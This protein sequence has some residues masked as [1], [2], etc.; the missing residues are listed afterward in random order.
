[1]FDLITGKVQHAPRHQTLPVFISVAAHVTIV[2]AMVT[3]TAVAVSDD[4]PEMPTIMAFVAAPPPPSPPP[5]P[6]APEPARQFASRPVPTTGAAAPVEPPAEVAPE[7]PPSELD[8]E[9]F[10]G[11]AGGVPGGIVGGV[12]GGLESLLPLPPPPP[13]RR[14]PVRVGG[15]I[16]EPALIY[17]VEPVYPGVAIS[18]N[19]EGTVILE[20]IVDE[21]GR[22]E[23]VRVLRSVSV[24]DR[25]AVEAVKQWRYSP[26]ILNGKPE[27]FILTVAVTFRLEEK[28]R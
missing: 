28:K 23:T 27:T 24:L 6:K 3:A 7:R 2:G 19:I 13:A 9:G 17:R 10:I 26:V 1:M 22:V 12:V 20:A 18:A 16:K 8:D 15:Q 4:L 21:D 25:A 5:P 14:G 11:S